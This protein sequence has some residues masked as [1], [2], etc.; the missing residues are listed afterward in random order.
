MALGVLHGAPAFGPG[1]QQLL[2]AAMIFVL[3]VSLLRLTLIIFPLCRRL[4]LTGAL[5]IA[6][7]AAY[8]IFTIA[9]QFLASLSASLLG[10]RVVDDSGLTLG[11]F[12][13]DMACYFFL[14]SAVIKH[15]HLKRA[16][17]HTLILC[18]AW[19]I[20]G[21]AAIYLGIADPF[22]GKIS[23]ALSATLWSTFAIVIYTVGF[24]LRIGHAIDAE[25]DGT[26]VPHKD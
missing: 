20:I 22:P 10:S 12:S 23:S 19:T 14:L 11:C 16:V 7:T 15:S 5:G 26:G 1:V 25:N 17:V 24:L 13:L 18:A 4:L 9:P 8:L 3:G 21:G 2:T 6:I